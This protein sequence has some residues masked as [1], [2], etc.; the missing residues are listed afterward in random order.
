MKKK[1]AVYPGTFD[2]ITF[3]HIDIVDRACYLF[4]NVIVAIAENPSKQPLFSVEERKDMIRESTRSIENVEVDAFEGLLVE[5]ATLRNA[6]AII[7]GLRAVTDFEYEL[8]MALMNR[9]LR[10]KIATV[11][12]MP[13]EEYIYL[14]SSIVKEVASFGE[15]V[16]HLVPEIVVRKLKETYSLGTHHSTRRL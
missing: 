1:I 8:Q 10:D 9:N 4:D 13:H 15:D 5:Y 7:R 14:N 3:G 12:L 16:S 11:F 6:V 2:P